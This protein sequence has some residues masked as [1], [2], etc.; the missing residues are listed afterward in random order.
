[1]SQV[2]LGTHRE[3]EQRAGLTLVADCDGRRLVVDRD[4]RVWTVRC[5]RCGQEWGLP[6][7]HADRALRA[8]HRLQDAGLPD[9]YARVR[10]RED[11][12]NQDPL[13]AVLEWVE[14][15]AGLPA[16][17]LFGAA[18]RGKTMLLAETVRRL[19]RADVGVWFCSCARLLDR[20]R[21]GLTDGSYRALWRR[22]VGVRVLVLDDVGAHRGTEW[23]VDR[24]ARLV[25]ERFEGMLPI[26]GAMN[27]PPAEWGDV[28]DERTVSRLRGM[29]FPVA[30]AGPDRR[31]KGEA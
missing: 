19:A 18:G 11:R 5:E 17:V 23:E 28:L 10:F 9:R 21:D 29:T 12:H 25:D 24:L 13:R 4:E 8:E 14:R 27:L 15:G 31:T 30:V 22:A 2:V 16:P 20:L 26:V 6:A 1:M 3:Y 7:R